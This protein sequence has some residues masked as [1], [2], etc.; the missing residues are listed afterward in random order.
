MNRIFRFACSSKLLLA[1]VLL[2][3]FRGT[4]VAGEI[5]F[6]FNRNGLSGFSTAG[7]ALQSGQFNLIA[8]PLGATLNEEDNSGVGVDSTNALNSSD[9]DVTKL[10]QISGSPF[11]GFEGVTFSFNRPGVLQRVDLDGLKDETLEYVTLT[12]PQGVV[13]SLLDFEV[14]LRL[15]QQGFQLSQ[16]GVPNPTLADGPGDDFTG[17]SIPFL[18]NELFTLTYGQID[19]DG[20]VLPGYQPEDD[21]GRPT[22][23][24][25]NGARLQGLGFTLV[26]EPNTGL[27]LL[28]LF[29]SLNLRMPCR[30][31]E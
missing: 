1:T 14:E 3:S 6:G 26:P 23:D 11:T 29:A 18:A 31:A 22:G 16:L 19:Y 2:Y 9:A 13:L 21:L 28:T 15:N 12:T 5:N 4:V 8:M 25:P 17:L 24:L 20:A 10:N 27:I 7:I 30:R